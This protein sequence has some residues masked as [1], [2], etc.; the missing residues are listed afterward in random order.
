MRRNTV[1]HH[2]QSIV[3]TAEKK[4][5]LRGCYFIMREDT[6]LRRG[7]PSNSHL[8]EPERWGVSLVATSDKGSALDPQTFE[9]V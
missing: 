8:P 9:K 4:D 5:P 7:L 1:S 2:Y 6:P 3:D